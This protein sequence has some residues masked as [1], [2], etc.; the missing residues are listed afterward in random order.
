MSLIVQVYI[1]CGL[2]YFKVNIIVL[3]N[4]HNRRQ[5]ASDN[6]TILMPGYPADVTVNRRAYGV[7][8]SS[9]CVPIWLHGQRCSPHLSWRLE[10]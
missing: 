8:L 10:P 4:Y 3:R 9:I 6:C 7:F 1:I 2:G 5:D